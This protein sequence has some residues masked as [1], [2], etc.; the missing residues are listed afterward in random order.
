[1]TL[2]VGELDAGTDP[3]R[4]A[5]VTFTRAARREV[6]DRVHDR[7]GHAA[8]P[9]LRTIHSAAYRL[10]ELRRGRI[11]D[12]QAWAKFGERYGY[13]FTPQGQRAYDPDGDPAALLR[14]TEEDLARYVSEWGRNC[15]LTHAQ[16]LARCP[17][18]GL[19]SSLYVAFVERLERFKRAENLLDFTDLLERVL[20]LGLRP[21]VDV[22]F[23][24]EAQDLS[25]LQAAVCEAWFEPCARSYVAGDE[26]QAVY[27]FQGAEPAWLLDLTRRR[28]PEILRQS[29]RVPVIAHTLALKTI[30][31]NRMRREKEYA[32]MERVGRVVHARREDLLRWLDPEVETFV[33][34]RNR[35]YLAPIA[36]QLLDLGFP[37]VVEGIGGPSPMSDERLLLAISVASLIAGPDAET[38]PARDIRAL[39][40]HVHA[41]PGLVAS[42]AKAK[43]K[44]AAKER[45]TLAWSELVDL[46]LQPLLDMIDREGPL[47]FLPERQRRYFERLFERYGRI[48]EPKIVLTTAHGSKGRGATRVIVIPDMSRATWNEYRRGGQAGF[49][50]ED[51]VFYVA[52][53]R[54]KEELV[55]LS[56]RSRRHFEFPHLDLVEGVA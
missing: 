44:E 39:L 21:D 35:V 48:P 11:L 46:G 25:P 38:F 36:H 30:R 20:E 16:T 19:K 6:Q 5:F 22:A 12:D 7:F 54:A 28:E 49:E 1:M 17:V 52:M 23:I 56:P 37:Y 55:L 10:L 4:I 40:D 26:D 51:R 45:G 31:Q 41:G 50:A 43:V 47:S 18:T 2:L 34:A 42:G 3:E 24:D 53:T 13:E 9:W 33:L 32:P 8:L 15:R 29:H 14:R 27:S